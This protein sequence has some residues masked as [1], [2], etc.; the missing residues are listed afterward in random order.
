MTDW[1]NEKSVGSAYRPQICCVGEA[2]VELSGL[3]FEHGSAQMNF[4]GDTMN[5]AVYLNRLVSSECQVSY[6]TAL[7][8]DKISAELISGLSQQGVGVDYV[9]VRANRLPGIYSIEL[10]EQG[11]RSFKYWRGESAAKTLFTEGLPTL[12]DLKI[13]DLI[14]F[15]GISLAILPKP[16][17][18]KMLDQ[19]AKLRAKGSIVVFDPNYRTQLWGNP[20]EAAYW[21]DQAWEVTDLGLP[22]IEDMLG[23]YGD[24]PVGDMVEHI[25]SKGVTEIVL[26]KGELAPNLYCAD[27]EF[28]GQAYGSFSPKL[29]PAKEIVDTTGAGDSFNAAY[30]SKR[31]AGQDMEKSVF[32]AHQLALKVISQ[33]GAIIFPD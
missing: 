17:R 25:R 12:D 5:T 11:E 8:E 1:M 2:L 21:T 3:D 19:L 29:A 18:R 32:E 22:S 23:L 16:T 26:K 31:L 15:T 6:V 13:F 14:Y 33:S 24:Q 9:G 28:K 20:N 10:D 4:A 30:L 27:T 7:G